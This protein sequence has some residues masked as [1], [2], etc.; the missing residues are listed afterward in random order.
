[1]NCPTCGKDTKVV[2]SRPQDD[3]VIRRRRVCDAG[4]RFN[5]W[6][7]SENLLRLRD[8]KRKALRAHRARRSR[9][10]IIAQNKRDHTRRLA[11]EE[12]RA[13]G[14]DVNV[15]YRKYGVE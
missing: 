4:H 3:N 8:N 5:T 1:M 12:A 15:L 11:R 13:T 2:D 7:T 9:E 6:E 10:E 14:V